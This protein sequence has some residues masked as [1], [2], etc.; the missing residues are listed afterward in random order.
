MVPHIRRVVV[1]EFHQV[2]LD[3]PAQDSCEVEEELNGIS[4]QDS[5]AIEKTSSSRSWMKEFD[6]M[7]LNPI[8]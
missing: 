6:E 3:H 1:L 4:N 5:K 2:R 7:K 8:G